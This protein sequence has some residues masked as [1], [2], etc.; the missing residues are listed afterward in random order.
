MWLPCNSKEQYF[1]EQVNLMNIS[2]GRK[3]DKA[4]AEHFSVTK[5]L[6]KFLTKF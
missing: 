3:K 1:S 6:I 5:T 4:D 2:K